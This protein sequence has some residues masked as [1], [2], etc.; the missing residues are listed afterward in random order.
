MTT[1]LPTKH[2]DLIY[3]VGMHKGEDTEF[4]LKK[5][6]RVIGFE[7]DPDLTAHCKRQFSAEINNTRL[8]IVE[9]AIVDNPRLDKVIFY[10]NID[11][12]FLGTVD[13]RWAKRNE[14]LGN[15]SD[16]IEVH[17]VDF[18]ECLRK[19]GIPYYMK[20]DIEG[21]DLTC[22]KQLFDSTSRPDYI[23][24]ESDKLSMKGICEE[25]HLLEQLGYNEFKAVQQD[26]MSKTIVPYPPREG[27][28]VS[29]TFP[30]GSSGLFGKELPGQWK[31]KEDIVKAY[32]SI[33]LYYRLFGDDG[34]ARKI[35]IVKLFKRLLRLITR[36]P[37]PGWYDTH[38]KHSSVQTP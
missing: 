4:Y 36:G 3:D 9:G 30:Q 21:A 12:T 15:T 16:I 1:W 27:V 37:V 6:F 35:V 26:H 23:S 19:Y 7:A 10:R 34:L 20:I 28:F 31:S 2:E 5:G 32:K 22:L 11:D 25:I 29:H 8:V 33:L 18:S 14:K 38:A 13:I 17:T 24:I